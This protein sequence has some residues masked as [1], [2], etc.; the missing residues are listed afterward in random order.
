MIIQW[1]DSQI[2]SFFAQASAGIVGVYSNPMGHIQWLKQWQIYAFFSSF[3]PSFRFSN[4]YAESMP[5]VIYFPWSLKEMR[6]LPYTPKCLFSREN[7]LIRVL[8]PVNFPKLM[9]WYGG[10]KPKTSNA[11]ST[12]IGLWVPAPKLECRKFH[13]LVKDEMPQD[14][15][16][17]GRDMHSHRRKSRTLRSRICSY[18]IVRLRGMSATRSVASF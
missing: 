16:Y 12:L 5:P 9:P 4:A 1:F 11:S 17:C 13:T 2:S 14:F 18:V 8:L 7:H 6:D 10:L 15:G 3:S